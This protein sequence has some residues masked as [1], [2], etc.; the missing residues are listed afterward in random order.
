MT[1]RRGRAPKID[2]VTSWGETLPGIYLCKDGRLR[3]RGLANVA[4]GGDEAAAVHK[5]KR[6]LAQRSGQREYVMLA[7][8]NVHPSW[9]PLAEADRCLTEYPF[10][11]PMKGAELVAKL[12]A[13]T[14]LYRD[15]Y[16]G[17]ILANPALAAI[18]LD[19]PHLAHYPEAPECPQ[20]TLAELGEKY[21]AEK[22]NK[23]GESLDEK[24][25]RN[26]R[27]WWD[28]FLG[29]VGV[30]LA[31]EVTEDRVKAYYDAVMKR[32]D[33]GL[34]AAY[35]KSRFVKIR[36]IVA[37]GIKHTRDKVELRRLADLL[38]PLESPEQVINPLPITPV[39]FHKLYKHA[40]A[41]EKVAL[42]LGLNAA[43]HLGEVAALRLAEIDLDAGTL[44]A[45]RPKNQR[46]RVAKL[47]PRT[48]DALREYVG[49]SQREY[50]FVSR[51][52]KPLTGE[53]LRQKIS[54]ARKRAK[55]P[56]HVNFDGL[57]DAAYG[58][59]EDVDAHFAKYLAGHT[60]GE[61][62][63]YVFRQATS[64]KI[65]E[66]CAAIEAHFFGDTT[67]SPQIGYSHR[68]TQGVRY[69]CSRQ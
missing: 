35:V 9:A 15:Y 52:G 66:C 49:Q 11:E 14:R 28:E 31:R 48:V 5:A 55:L 22:R 44:R 60:T 1:R 64:R 54:F 41:R 63:K 25:K 8:M 36:A 27:K 13:L 59:A 46:A 45:R 12:P 65:A 4:F 29:I 18:A 67:A 56:K 24:H 19:V 61:N 33:D 57:R 32:F 16:R 7:D 53:N 26:S 38:L 21:L 69:G 17:L 23:A 40:R 30:R 58:L 50:L 39:H 20:Y 62:D 43:M 2:Y 37:W 42:L 51:T 34:S 10:G 6:W 68:S 47:W 3:P